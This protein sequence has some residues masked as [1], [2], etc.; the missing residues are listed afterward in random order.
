MDYETPRFNFGEN[1]RIELNQLSSLSTL[2]T[3]YYQKRASSP[4]FKSKKLYSPN[5]IIK[6]LSD[7]TPIKRGKLNKISQPKGQY[8][9][10]LLKRFFIRN[11]FD[12]EHVDEFLLS[13][14]QAFELPL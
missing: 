2:L 4:Q 13:K 3:E 11:D 14:E 1:K 7:L 9:S 6:K 10:L 8:A 5:K 12:K